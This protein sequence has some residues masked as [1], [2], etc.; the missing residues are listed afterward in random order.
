MKLP[1]FKRITGLTAFVLLL[2]SF[3]S[4]AD[5]DLSS[6]PAR[7]SP[8][9]LRD[10][11]I[12]EIFPRDFSPAGNLDGVTA[13]LDQLQSLGVNIL[14]LMPIHPIGE[15]FRK[16]E[17][18]SPY[19]V[20]DYYAINPDYGT[21]DDFKKLVA[22]A[23]KRGMKVIMDL[24]ANHTAWDSVVMEHPDF[25]KHNAQGNIIPPVPEWTDVAALNYTNASLREYMIAMLTYWV[26]TYG[27]DGFRCDSAAM[28]P[29][30]FWQQARAALVK[31][32]PEIIL[33]A[34]ASK[35]ELLVSAFDLD[36]SWPLLGAEDQVLLNGA[37]ALSIRRS[38]EKSRLQFPKGALH[39]EISD[40]HDEARAINRFGVKG[41]L[42]ASALIFTL[43]GVPLIYNGMEIGDAGESSGDAL[44]RKKNISWQTPEHPDLRDTYQDLIRL[45][46]EYPALCNSSVQWLHNSEETKLLTF[47]RADDKDEL[48]VV[49][50]F[51][52][53]PASGKI[54]LK[55]PEGFTPVKISG[56]PG[57]DDSPLPAFHL[58]GYEWRIF[59]RP[60]VPAGAL[61][62]LE[63]NQDK[64]IGQN[65]H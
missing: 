53:S 7:S 14:W 12:Y 60:A 40:D 9:W 18:G 61:A 8:Q 5:G 32:D 44:F 34:E 15:K 25:Y 33:L 20:K 42:A 62:H 39:M 3:Y 28:V 35:P 37:P 4:R 47:L 51:S 30:D 48:L 11:V 56:A 46:H 24:V 55:N 2:S 36:Y 52:G 19:S 10:S 63:N 23:H 49:I 50:N 64:S 57:S 38:W 26:Q 1:L 22:E 54:D 31:V 29:T 58:D 45:R 59:H 41:A 27:V 17:F 21:P 6:F 43:D 13:K 16:G 65:E